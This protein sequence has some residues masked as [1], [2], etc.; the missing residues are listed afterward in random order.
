MAK[1]F[2]KYYPDPAVPITVE[3]QEFL[4]QWGRWDEA[5]LRG[6]KVAQGEAVGES[7]GDPGAPGPTDPSSG[8]VGA[9]TG[10]GDE[11]DAPYSEWTNDEL[12]AEL[13]VRNL[14]VGGTHDELVARLEA[15]DEE[16]SE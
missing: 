4:K 6:V 11:E 5:E 12:K 8:A 10:S 7:E 14:K 1:K 13:K 3:H 2:T 16:A 15:D 9:S